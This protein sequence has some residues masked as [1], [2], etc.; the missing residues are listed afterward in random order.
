[1]SYGYGGQQ[2]QAGYGQQPY[3][4]PQQGMYG[5]PQGIDPSIYQWFLSVDN[6]RSGQI[7]ATEL[8]QALSNAPWA[9]FTPETCRLMISTFDQDRTGTISL[10]EF[11]AL[12]NYIT[13]WRAIFDQ[14]DRDRSGAVDVGELNA[15]LTQMGYRLSPQFFQ[16]LIYRYDPQRKQSLN[17]DSFIQ[18]CFLLKSCTDLFRTKDTQQRG[19]IQ[20]GYEEFLGA[21]FANKF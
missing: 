11:Q 12:F 18:A 13:Q 14:Y 1:M 8:L 19:V 4:Q 17:F 21:I 6:D 2:P 3:G 7:S 10:Q 5:P 16:T 15:M 20:I 9:R